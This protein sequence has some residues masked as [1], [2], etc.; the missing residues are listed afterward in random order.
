MALG[1]D[2]VLLG[3]PY[4]WGL[5]V[6]GEQGVDAVIRQVLA[7]TDLTLALSGH[8]SVRTLDRDALAVVE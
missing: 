5:A 6:G 8:D 7:E 2:A 1:A 4:V 3:R